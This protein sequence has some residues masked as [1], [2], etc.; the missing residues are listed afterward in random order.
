[1][2]P[3]GVA[4]Y[5]LELPVNWTAARL[6]ST[7]NDRGIPFPANTR[8]SALLRLLTSG[9]E[10]FSNNATVQSNGDRSQQATLNQNN[11]GSPQ[12]QNGSAQNFSMMVDIVSKLPSTVQ[13]SQQN[14][15]NLTARVNSISSTQCNGPTQEN[16]A[17]T[18]GP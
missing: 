10:H 15:I 16:N 1:M 2:G 18:S 4:S 9:P 3:K 13:P 6:K 7:L 14:V 11:N 5:N 17:T 12:E 8:R